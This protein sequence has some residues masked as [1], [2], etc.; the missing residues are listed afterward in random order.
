VT[1][2][3]GSIEHSWELPETGPARSASVPV[4]ASVR[5]IGRR[6]LAAA[7]VPR[8]LVAEWRAAHGRRITRIAALVAGAIGFLLIAHIVL[9]LFSPPSGL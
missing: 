9:Y 7:E 8:R 5:R 4:P 3:P 6:V 2:T 1:E